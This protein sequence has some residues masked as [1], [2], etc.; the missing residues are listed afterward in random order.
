MARAQLYQFL[1]DEGLTVKEVAERTGYN[2]TYVS[3][4]LNGKTPLSASARLRFIE[5]FPATALFLLP[6]SVLSA[7]NSEAV[8]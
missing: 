6:D 8:A 2:Y 7:A 1:K 3:E 4:L 5:A